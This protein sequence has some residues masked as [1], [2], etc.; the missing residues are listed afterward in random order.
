MKLDLT[1]QQRADAATRA[2]VFVTPD[3]VLRDVA[4]RLWEEAVGAAVVVGPRGEVLG[5]IS[6]RD[7]VTRLAWGADPDAVTAGE[8]MTPHIVAAYPNDLVI[9]V[10]FQMID[11][12]IR[13]VP[14]IDDAGDVLGMVSIRD[15][16]RPLLVDAMGG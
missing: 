4:R 1:T 2:A 3:E 9:D 11:N 8:A 10:A 16:V 15:L 5:V 12:A 7:V 13:H 14:V 6:E